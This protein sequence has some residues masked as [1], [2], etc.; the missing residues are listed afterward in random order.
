M[1]ALRQRETG[2]VSF[3]T[4]YGG[5]F[6]LSTWSIKPKSSCYI[7]PPTQHHSFFKNL[8][9]FIITSVRKTF[10]LISGDVLF[11]LLRNTG[12]SGSLIQHD[13]FAIIMWPIE[14]KSSG[15]LFHE[16]LVWSYIAVLNDFW[17]NSA[18]PF[19]LKVK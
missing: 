2:N 15:C 5:Q 17:L 4:L 8:S 7:T 11:S 19:K 13:I 3:E 10:I 6:S 9:S 12:V 18:I 16:K 14:K 1:L